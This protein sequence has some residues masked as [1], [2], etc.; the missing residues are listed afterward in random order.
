METLPYLPLKIIF[1]Q[2]TFQDILTLL[3]TPQIR[4]V[5]LE[6]YKKDMNMK[7]LIRL[8]FLE[9]FDKFLY[10]YSGHY[11]EYLEDFC[12]EK[13]MKPFYLSSQSH[14]AKKNFLTHFKKQ[15]IYSAF[16]PLQPLNE[17]LYLK[18]IV[19]SR[20]LFDLC[21]SVCDKLSDTRKYYRILETAELDYERRQEI[22]ISDFLEI[23]LYENKYGFKNTLELFEQIP[24]FNVLKNVRKSQI[25]EMYSQ[26]KPIRFLL[27]ISKLFVIDF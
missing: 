17:D 13:G 25:L 22:Y 24:S 16:P 19:E 23:F 7:D 27:L 26:D 15:E 6:F 1:D 14:Q 12:I 3:W 20:T 8:G 21:R 11:I 9:I 10:K 5:I 4:N 2:L 18:E